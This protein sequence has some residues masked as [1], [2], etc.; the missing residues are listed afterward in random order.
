MTS[1]RELRALVA[2]LNIEVAG[3]AVNVIGGCYA[4]KE[5]NK[6]CKQSSVP[7]IRV[8]RPLPRQTQLGRSAP[9]TR[10]LAKGRVAESD[11]VQ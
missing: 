10:R 11:T 3:C 5:T 6:L 8:A 4:A 7:V 1:T 9:E 2:F